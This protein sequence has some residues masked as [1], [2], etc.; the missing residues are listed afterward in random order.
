MATYRYRVI[1]LDAGELVRKVPGTPALGSTGPDQFVDIVLGDA[2]YKADLDEFMASQGY[3]YASTNPVTT[4]AEEGSQSIVQG[5]IIEVAKSGAPFTSVKAANDSILDAAKTKPYVIQ[6]APGDYTEDPFTCKPYVAI[7][8]V[9][10][11]YSTVLRTTD[12][13]AHFLTGAA[14]AELANVVLVGP[15]GVGYAA[16]DYQTSGFVPFKLDHVVIRRGYYGVWCH[17]AG[18]RGV[19]HCFFVV[20]HYDGVPIHSMFRSTDFGNITL[21]NS[22]FMSGPP[23]AVVNGWD[24]DG[25]DAEATLDAC[26]FRCGGA[27]VALCIDNG[28]EIRASACTISMAG[29]GVCVGAGGGHLHA[30]ACVL[31]EGVSTHIETTNGPLTIISFV[32]MADTDK[33]NLAVGTVI[34]ATY[35]DHSSATTQGFVIDGE[36]W[37]GDTINKTPL[38]SYVLATGDTG[39]ATGGKL[40]YGGGL[41]L[42]VSAGSGF[43][44]STTKMTP[45]S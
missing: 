8:G 43:V 33:L 12:D 16:V 25:A 40:S 2:A 24:L 34:V 30:A 32:G 11:F 28:A 7:V 27:A 4:P 22:G 29:K 36:V 45:V 41:H 9:G 23:N 15:T 14:G 10:G 19:I 35:N 5:Q 21:V 38:R 44:G 13:N 3:E 26:F 18:S 39:L 42:N 6:V 37:V 1:S 20:N 17:P 31:A